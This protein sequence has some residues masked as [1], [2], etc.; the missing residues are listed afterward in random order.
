MKETYLTKDKAFIFLIL[1]L[2]IV[3]LLNPFFGYGRI[4]PAAAGPAGGMIINHTCTN[5]NTIPEVALCPL[6]KA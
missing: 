4:E 2:V 6:C 1:G 5:I 3:A